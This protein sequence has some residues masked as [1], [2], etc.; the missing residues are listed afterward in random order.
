[1]LLMF[2]CKEKKEEEVAGSIPPGPSGAPSLV[3][4]VQEL[5]DVVQHRPMCVWWCRLARRS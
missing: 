2:A 1:M 3:V 4:V 5:D